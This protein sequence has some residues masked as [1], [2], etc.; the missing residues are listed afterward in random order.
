[1]LNVDGYYDSLLR[2]FD[3][4]V[5]E[6]FIKSSARNIVISAKNAKDLLQGMEVPNLLPFKP[7]NISLSFFTFNFYF[8]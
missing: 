1:M 4:G 8:L 3:K 7:I 5:E 6:G 2:F